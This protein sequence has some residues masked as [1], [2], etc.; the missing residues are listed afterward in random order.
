M[1]SGSFY[2]Q[3]LLTRLKNNFHSA[4]DTDIGSF[5]RRYGKI[6]EHS[7]DRYCSYNDRGETEICKRAGYL[8]S[9]RVAERCSVPVTSLVSSK[10]VFRTRRVLPTIF[11]FFGFLDRIIFEGLSIVISFCG[12]GCSREKSFCGRD[13]W[14]KEDLP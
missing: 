7:A 5:Y 9:D 8:L 6:E 3:S 14:S 11:L 13:R 1:P 2:L 4:G 12:D 10:M